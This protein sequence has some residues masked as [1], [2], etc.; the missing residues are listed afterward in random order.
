MGVLGGWSFSYPPL[1][2]KIQDTCEDRIKEGRVCRGTLL[3]R[4]RAPLLGLPQEP[5][6]GPTAGPYGVAVFCERNGPVGQVKDKI[7]RVGSVVFGVSPYGH[8]TWGI[9]IWGQPVLSATL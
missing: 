8:G 2:G 3:I 6:H 9:R 5:S 4:N 1:S 7:S